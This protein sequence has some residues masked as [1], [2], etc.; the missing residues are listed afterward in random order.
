MALRNRA[1]G[2]GTSKK[3]ASSLVV[4]VSLL[5][6]M[7]PKGF[8]QGGATDWGARVRALVGNNQLQQAM[9][10][11][12]EW[13]AA[14]PEDLD[15][16]GWHARV[17]AWTNHWDSAEAEY[18]DLLRSSPDDVDL[19]A[20]LA[21]LLVW[22]ERFGEALTLLERAC[23]LAPERSD[24]R[25]RLARV[26]R[27][28]G[29]TGEARTR[30]REVLV[31]DK[32]SREAKAG[33]AEL[34]E[35][36]RHELR[37]GF[38]ADL[39]SYAEDAGAVTT[40]LQS[41]WN[42]RW[43]SNAA[44]S[45]FRRFR[46]D[47]TRFDAD[48]T[49]RLDSRNALTMGGSTAHDAGVI[50]KSEARFELDHGQ[51]LSKSGSVRGIEVLYQQRWVWYQDARLLVLS[52]GAVLYFPRDWNWLVRLAATRS[53]FSGATSQWK[54]GG[55]TRLSFPV[56]R[57]LAGHV[58]FAVGTENFG[59]VDEIREFSARTWGGGLRVRFAAGQEIMGY[60]QY[61]CRSSGQ[62]ETSIGI[63]YAV[64]F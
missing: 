14:Y 3:A 48:A 52:P 5:L 34:R 62:S 28:L 59:L 47:A 37:V 11:I 45:Q 56:S 6:F 4:A 21:D 16:R 50:P 29:R 54:P 64:R 49:M 51:D 8:P 9:S 36:G 31:R 39:L 1:E 63:N 38:E 18:R 30:Y 10:L 53:H 24:C 22:Q 61:Q 7:A 60:A 33:L 58:L 43:S 55:W 41:R 26:L 42:H 15:A 13:I 40:S 19:L 32:G 27:Y 20:G 57:N 46:E 25:L 35:E 17:L 12:E 2:S 44:I 23:S